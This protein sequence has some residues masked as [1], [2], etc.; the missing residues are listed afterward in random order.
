MDAFTGQ[1]G[2]EAQAVTEQLVG[3]DAGAVPSWQRRPGVVG[4]G[5]EERK[6]QPGN[7]VGAG[8]HV[9]GQKRATFYIYSYIT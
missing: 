7:L 2:V 5:A 6:I 1:S 9:G 8:R 4:S 3:G